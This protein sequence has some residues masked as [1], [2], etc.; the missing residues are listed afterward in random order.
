MA[1]AAASLL[2]GL[3]LLRFRLLRHSLPLSVESL[4]HSRRPWCSAADFTRQDEDL[5]SA[6]KTTPELGVKN[7]PKSQR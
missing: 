2:R 7:S 6:S 1:A 3:P 4:A 5:S